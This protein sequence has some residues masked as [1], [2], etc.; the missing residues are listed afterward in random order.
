[1]PKKPTA[2]AAERVRASELRKI[3]DGGR[4]MPGGVMPADAADALGVLQA[5]GYGDSASTCIYR[6]IVEAAERYRK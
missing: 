4:R 3:R 6:A 5:E 1:M 2:T